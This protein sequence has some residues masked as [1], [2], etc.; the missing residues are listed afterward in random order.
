MARE[1]VAPAFITWEKGDATVTVFDDN[2][3]EHDIVA[4]FVFAVLP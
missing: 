4:L 2:V 3:P 1:T